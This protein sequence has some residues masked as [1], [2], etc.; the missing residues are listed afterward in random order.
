MSAREQALWTSVKETTSS[1]PRTE[2][3][4]SRPKVP[5]SVAYPRPQTA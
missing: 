1:T 5:I 3:T 4:W 2:K